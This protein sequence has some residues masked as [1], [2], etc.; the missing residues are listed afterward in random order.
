VAESQL[1]GLPEN[2]H[3]FRM[4]VSNSKSGLDLKFASWSEG[5]LHLEK[6]IHRAGRRLDQDT[7][8]VGRK[9]RKGGGQ[10]LVDRVS[11]KGAP[12]AQRYRER[13]SQ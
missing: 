13:P 4:D 10:A 1:V 5:G 9:S 6:E 11:M 7:G 3:C 12:A 8:I 2:V